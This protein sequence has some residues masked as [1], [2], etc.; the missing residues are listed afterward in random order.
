LLVP[1]GTFYRSY[2]GVDFT[3]KSYPATVSDFYLDKYEITVGRVRAFVIAGMGT[4]TNPPAPGT[5]ASPLITGSGWDSAWNASLPKDTASLEA[6]LKCDATNQ[7][8]TD[9]AGSNESKPVNCLDWYTAFAFCAWDGGRLPT[10]AEWN[11]AAAGGSE[12]RYYPW[13]SPPTSTT[14]DDS[15]TVYCGGSCG[16]TQNVG[17]K[18]PKGDGKWGQSDLAGNVEEWTLDW[19]TSPYSMP[20]ANCAY[21]TEASGSYRA[22]RG[23]SFNGVF[24]FASYLRSAYRG[25]DNPWDIYNFIGVRCAR[26]SYGTGSGSS[27][28][29]VPDAPLAQPDVPIGGSGGGTGGSGGAG[30]AGGGAAGS[31]GGTIIV[32]TTG[33]LGPSCTGLPATCGPSGDE[34]CCTNLLVPG[35]T[36]YRSNDTNYPATVSDF[37]LGKYEITVGRFRAFVNAGMGTQASP[38]APGAGAHPLITASGWDSTW[39]TYLPADTASLEAVIKC[40]STLQTWTDI[41]AG[42]ENRPM[43]CLDWYTA[44]AFCA[45]DGVRLPTE[46][47]WNYA[48]AGGSEQRV[49]PWSNPPTSTTI[50]YTMASYECMGDGIPGCALTDFIL[51]GTKPAGNGRWGHADLAGNLIE[52]TLDWYSDAYP[53]PCDDFAELT[54]GPGRAQR[55][56]HYNNQPYALES[57][58]RYYSIPRGPA[59]TLGARCAI[60]AQQ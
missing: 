51:V 21:L 20:C 12:Q 43:N 40:N 28:A 24:N 34:S 4:Q 18:S 59:E 55:G 17:S 29:G 19:Y 25:Y 36:F 39:N 1:G 2:D 50:D 53:L 58:F 26:T 9:K 23:S 6:A 32:T 54:L 16:G 57:S 41:P 35:G 49:F 37:Y 46:A 8:W 33:A 47:E 45:W 31:T 14:L 30:G 52:W 56:G 48:A 5:G 27:D 7:T 22:I 11:Y 60:T 42:G 3:D 10:E 38:P 13:S 44:F 15:Y